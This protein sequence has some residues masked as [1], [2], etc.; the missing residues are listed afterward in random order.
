LAED[1]QAEI[2]RLTAEVARRQAD[3]AKLEAEV[4]GLERELADFTTR[5]ERIVR[6]VE[7]MLDAV[8]AA[9]EELE[10]QRFADTYADAR[11]LESWTQADEYV[12]VEE[13]YRRVWGAPP[14]ADHPSAEPKPRQSD[15]GGDLETRLKRLFRALARRYHPDLATDEADRAYRTALMTMINEAY[16]ARD[17]ETLQTLMDQGERVSADQPLAVLRLRT[18]KQSMAALERRID[19]LAAE[20]AALLHSDVMS[21]KVEDKMAAFKGRNLLREMAEELETEYWAQVARLDALR[22]NDGKP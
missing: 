11:P 1:I 6:P 5:Y 4:A 17:V 7:A 12:S 14:P 22:S 18:L 3:A 19:A 13:Q 8:K 15:V 20:R 21:L 16:T 10:H 2:E 9:I